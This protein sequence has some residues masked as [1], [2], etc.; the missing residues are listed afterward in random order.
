MYVW[1]CC[2]HANLPL[3]VQQINEIREEIHKPVKTKKRIIKRRLVPVTRPAAGVRTRR[4]VSTGRP[5]GFIHTRSKSRAV[6]NDAG[7]AKF[8]DFVVTVPKENSERFQGFEGSAILRIASHFMMLFAQQGGIVFEC[9]LSD[10]K[11]SACHNALNELL[12]TLPSFAMQRPA[13]VII[14]LGSVAQGGRSSLIFVSD[15][16]ED[17]M[18]CLNWYES[19]IIVV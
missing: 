16:A 15:S 11:R 2:L 6:S 18:G 13:T 1:F 9:K 5:Q 8:Y 4:V 3:K 19:H 10:V 14:K 12:T 17:I 7:A